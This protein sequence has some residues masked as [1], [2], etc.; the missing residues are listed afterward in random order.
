MPL[1]ADGNF[2]AR[3]SADKVAATRRGFPSF[4]ALAYRDV[5]NSW[6]NLKSPSWLSDD[7]TALRARY[8]VEI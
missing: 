4:P 3:S 7:V 5:W 8:S 1:A 2:I 6:E